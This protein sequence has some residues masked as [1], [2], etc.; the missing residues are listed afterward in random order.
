MH[1]GASSIQFCCY[2]FPANR[3]DSAISFN[4]WEYNSS[5]DRREIFRYQAIVWRYCRDL[6]INQRETRIG[7]RK[8]IWERIWCYSWSVTGQSLTIHTGSFCREMW[9]LLKS[10]SKYHRIFIVWKQFKFCPIIVWGM[11][12]FHHQD[13]RYPQLSA[14]K[15]IWFIIK[16]DFSG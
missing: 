8:K 4:I 2:R 1:W 16:I 11:S 3:K 15:Y 5:F 13:P 7:I 9:S 14:D 6:I 12:R 10:S